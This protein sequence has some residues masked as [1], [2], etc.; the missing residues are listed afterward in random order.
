MTPNQAKSNGWVGARQSKQHPNDSSY[1]FLN[2]R[3]VC[4]KSIKINYPT[5]RGAIAGEEVA[6]N[7]NFLPWH[8]L[9]VSDEQSEVTRQVLCFAR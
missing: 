6:K 2:C 4:G 9:E 5:P 8:S 7:E 1:V 3:I